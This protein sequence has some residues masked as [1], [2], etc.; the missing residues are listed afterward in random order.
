M[1]RC[2]ERSGTAR[3]DRAGG[4]AQSVAHGLPV[5]ATVVRMVRRSPGPVL[6]ACPWGTTIRMCSSGGGLRRKGSCGGPSTV[7]RWRGGS[8]AG[9]GGWSGRTPGRTSGSSTSGGQAAAACA[10]L[11]ADRFHETSAA[12]PGRRP[13]PRSSRRR[14]PRIVTGARW[15]ST[16][17]PG[18]GARCRCGSARG[19]AE[20]AGHRR[21]P[22]ENVEEAEALLSRTGERCGVLPRD[23]RQADRDRAGA[24]GLQHGGGAAEPVLLWW[25]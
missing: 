19:R 1:S 23:Q 17:D 14:S 11:Q 21:V 24:A 9:C 20:P 16:A 13:W 12:G 3:R 5:R 6:R 25:R 4:R 18:L 10:D 22:A 15:P 8:G 2:D 7:I